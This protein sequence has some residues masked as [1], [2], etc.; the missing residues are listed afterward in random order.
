M[1]KFE[2]SCSALAKDGN[3]PVLWPSEEGERSPLTSKLD[4]VKSV[5]GYQGCLA[6]YTGLDNLS[7]L[8]FVSFDQYHFPLLGSPI[9]ACH[10]LTPC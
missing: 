10:F 9:C 6:I 5:D 8:Y 2:Q 7:I 3:L 1:A 4:N